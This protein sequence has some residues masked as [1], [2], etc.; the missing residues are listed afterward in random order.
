MTQSYVLMVELRDG[1]Y[2]GRGE[3]EPHESDPSIMDEV[4]QIIE[5]LRR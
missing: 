2:I 1:K 5:G 4:E 3:C